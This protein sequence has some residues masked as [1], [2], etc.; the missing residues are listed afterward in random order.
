[1]KLW[2]F[3]K[4]QKDHLN[5]GFELPPGVVL[6]SPEESH[7]A[8]LMDMPSMQE[9]GTPFS[10]T[11]ATLEPMASGPLPQ[12]GEEP[13]TLTSDMM[14]PQEPF[15]SLMSMS[16]PA[17]A[18]PSPAFAEEAPAKMDLDNFFEQNSLAM[19][20]PSSSPA[21]SPVASAQSPSET[22]EMLDFLT[23]PASPQVAMPS[24]PVP[25]PT[26]QPLEAFS[27]PNPGEQSAPE[28]QAA[29]LSQAFSDS[30]LPGL[31]PE[32]P[33]ENVPAF[34][35]APEFEALAAPELQ[36]GPKLSPA[37]DPLA[38]AAVFEFGPSP[39]PK[40]LPELMPH[41]LA[42]IAATEPAMATPLQAT[43]EPMMSS[44]E[45]MSFDAPDL[46]MSSV[47]MGPGSLAP[48]FSNASMSMDDPNLFA[49]GSGYGLD[50][51]L[52]REGESGF[53]MMG[54]LAGEF[55]QPAA[56][57]EGFYLG[58]T[59]ELMPSP[60]DKLNS[61]GFAALDAPSLASSGLEILPEPEEE[62]FTLESG[63]S[64]EGIPFYGEALAE[65]TVSADTNFGFE[66]SSAESGE[67]CPP[68][69]MAA[70]FPDT[71]LDETRVEELD[72]AELPLDL[73]SYDLGHYPDPEEEPACIDL[74]NLSAGPELLAMMESP[75]E[76]EPEAHH[77]YL[78]PD[79]SADLPTPFSNVLNEAESFTL[80][81]SATFEFSE[82][83]PSMMECLSSQAPE[84]PFDSQTPLESPRPKQFA[85]APQQKIPS[86]QPAVQQ[87]AAFTV[88]PRE[89]L[90]QER[91]MVDAIHNFEH[92]IILSESR[93]LKKSLD[94]LVTRYFAEN[95]GGMG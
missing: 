16:Q 2:P 40:A 79:A 37:S 73:E 75:E 47:D 86:Q 20:S 69:D 3:S 30:F 87:P 74:D 29:P 27:L 65:D 51:P 67:L 90:P 39:E 82:P 61:P 43:E 62:P 46:T 85:Q 34:Q 91:S 80:G 60:I 53:G 6:A 88:Q 81:E 57:Q 52:K 84:M 9:S 22:S 18:E 64:D 15:P 77:L 59:E 4:K 49:V 5:S 41:T 13:F 78:E 10:A 71:V 68:G 7:V 58:F 24:I 48:D 8:D 38:A 35:V 50:N 83:Q 93:F 25:Y 94:D 76:M 42:S 23:P 28:S 14:A 33:S 21:S 54:E 63:N 12:A 32:S 89:V 26:P 44:F 95:G 45:G 31:Q 56:P 1:M 70:L 11:Q 72:D 19:I 17:S 55:P 36:F 92:Q 66:G